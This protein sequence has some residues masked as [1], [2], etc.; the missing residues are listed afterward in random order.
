MHVVKYL[1]SYLISIEQIVMPVPYS[2]LFNQYVHFHTSKGYEFS[3]RYCE[4]PFLLSETGIE[5]IVNVLFHWNSTA[6]A[7]RIPSMDAATRFA[8]FLFS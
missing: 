1:T 8:P 7:L 6:L 3:T 2:I 4:Y 5:D